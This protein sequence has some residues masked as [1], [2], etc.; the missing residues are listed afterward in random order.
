MPSPL[1]RDHERTRTKKG[2]WRKKRSDVGLKRDLKEYD[3]W[4]AETKKKVIVKGIV[5]NMI[6]PEILKT[7]HVVSCPHVKCRGKHK[8]D[9]IIHHNIQGNW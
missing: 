1:V 5:K 3:V 4:C 9:C 2:R 8:R 6:Y 7:L